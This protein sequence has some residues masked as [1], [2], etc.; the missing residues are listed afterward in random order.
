MKRHTRS[1][2][3]A[4]PPLSD[5]AAVVIL[6]FLHEAVQC[7]ESRYYTQIRRHYD[8]RCRRN[9]RRHEAPLVDS[10]DVPF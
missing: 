5:E 1:L 2:H 8:E 9:L 4:L 6:E 3:I 10:D 7:F